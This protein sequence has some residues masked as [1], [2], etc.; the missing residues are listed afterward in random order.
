MQIVEQ[1]LE[2]IT[3]AL[4]TLEAPWQDEHAV[5]VMGLIQ[6]VPIQN[7]YTA[8]DV[9]ALFEENFRAGF[10][11]AQLFLGISKDEFPDRL[12][13]IL[14]GENRSQDLFI[15]ARTFHRGSGRTRT[16]SRHGRRGELQTCMERHPD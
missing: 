2:D 11:A 15:R 7:A 12:G 14:A 10:T 5:K 1:T 16:S 3:G 9:G 13:A 4:T 8:E 6:N